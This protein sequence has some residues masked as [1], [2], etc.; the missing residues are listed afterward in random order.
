M[1]YRSVLFIIFILFFGL[2]SLFGQSKIIS[3]G[4]DWL[5]NDGKAALSSDWFKDKNI[6]NDWKTGISPLGYGDDIVATK[7]SFGAD[8]EN[9]HITV[10][11]KKTFLVSNPYKYLIYKLSVQRDDGIVIYLNG[12]EVMRNNMP[13]GEI[14]SDTKAIGLVFTSRVEKIAHTILLYPDDFIAGI[15][16]ITASVHQA[17]STSSDCLFNLE[18]LGDN[19]P[20]MIPILLKEQTIKNLNLVV[21]LEEANHAREIEKKELQLEF[22]EQSKNDIKIL[23]FV[24]VFLLL[25]TLITLYYTWRKFK[26]KKKK[27]IRNISKLTGANQV[28]DREM[29]NI[30]LAS[31]NEKQYI[32]ELKRDLEESIKNVNNKDELTSIIRKIIHGIDYNMDSGEDWENLKKHFN[33]VHTGYVDKI[34]NLHPLLTDIELRHCVFIKLLMQTK[35]IANILHIDPKSVQ[36]SRYRLK[37]KMNLDENSDL[38][39][40]LLNL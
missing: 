22:L 24:I 30:S 21:K 1:I 35:E 38:K 15:N 20:D 3:T 23:F 31:L 34:R 14:T 10:Y 19:N 36:V 27:L 4:D 40:Y 8:T 29:M 2:N 39:G 9:K 26:T 28:K 33:A 11:F 25:L 18:L 32:K 7:I 37:K 13:E 6:G 5:Y 17:R 16:T 12:H